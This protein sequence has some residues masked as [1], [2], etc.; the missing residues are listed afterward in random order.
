M[1]FKD[2]H[3]SWV[4]GFRKFQGLK[5]YYVRKLNERNTYCCVYHVKMDML[6]LEVNAM[7]T[8]SKGIHGELCVCTCEVCRPNGEEN[9]CNAR[10]MTYPSVSELWSVLCLLK[11]TIM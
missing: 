1:N 10:N 6:R 5:P 2:Q 4:V 9:R 8:N 3:P 7:H 11:R